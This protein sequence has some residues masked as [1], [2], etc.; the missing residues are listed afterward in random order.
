MHREQRERA[1]LLFKSKGIARALLASP[2]SVKWLTGFAP[3]VEIG[4]HLFAGGPPMIWYED[5]RFTLLVVDDWAA[6]AAEFGEQPDGGVETHLGYT[7]D[8]PLSGADHLGQVL[9]RVMGP[10]GRGRLGI[11][12]RDVP[13]YFAAVLAAAL[14]AGAE[15]VAVDRWLEPLRTVKTDEELTKLR[16][17]FALADIGQAAARRAVAAGEREIDVWTEVQGAVQRTAARRLPVGCDCVVGYRRNNVG[18]WPVDH[19]IR[20]HDSLLVDL[21]TNLSGYWSD[22]SGTYYAGEPTRQQIAL[23]RVVQSALDLAVSL[24]HPG[25][26][27]KEIDRAV[28]TFISDAGYP[29]Y[30]HHTGHGIGVGLHEAPRIVPYS[31]ERLE[32]GMV[33]MVEPG[34]YLP[35][36]TSVRLEDA[37]LVTPDGAE[38]LTTHDKSLP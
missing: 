27:A 15:Q 36:V 16:Q 33:I 3:P 25:A 8:R 34:I 38:V 13:D 22:G 20:W 9:R 30:P 32:A 17:N 24:V 35:G 6:D 37:V 5:G 19:E 31:E 1:H 18:G 4:A 7:L 11:E 26:V 2:A 21:C 12:E 23:H 29:V 28:R 14:P 10:V